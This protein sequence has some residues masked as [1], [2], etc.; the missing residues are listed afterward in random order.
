MRTILNLAAVAAF[1]AIAATA[2]PQCTSQPQS[3]WLPE[4]AIKDKA[5]AAG[6]KISV[7]KKTPGNCYEVYG[8]N[9]SGKRIEIYYNPMNGDIIK[10]SAR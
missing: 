7:F 3:A 8:R 5:H 6:H 2:E 10:E 4:A 1:P 9:A